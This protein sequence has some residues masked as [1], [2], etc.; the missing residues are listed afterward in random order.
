MN[1][2]RKII[3]LVLELLLVIDFVLLSL[4]LQERL[5]AST[6][7][8]LAYQNA[9][10]EDSYLTFN[11][12]E[13]SNLLLNPMNEKE[14]LK[15]NPNVIT[16]SKENS[17]GNYSVYFKY[18]KSSDLDYN[19]LNI[20]INGKTT[21]LSDLLEYET[22]K[23]KYFL[24]GKGNIKSSKNDIKYDVYFWMDES[25]GNEAQGKQLIYTFEVK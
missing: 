10:V 2:S 12:T 11:I 17:K 4:P 18:D 24:L 19:Y 14:A 21:R 22:S 8:M 1:I 20:N 23:Y 9:E 5:E 16:I 6:K 7:E 15:M 13:G 3:I 25:I